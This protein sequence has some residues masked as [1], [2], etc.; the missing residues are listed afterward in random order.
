[1]REFRG[2]ETTREVWAVIRAAHPEIEAIGSYSAPDGGETHPEHGRMYTAY[3][4][5]DSPVP[6]ISAET[7]WEIDRSDPLNR[8]NQQDRCWLCVPIEE[9]T[10]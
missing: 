4:F 8:I 2:V 10:E 1:M 6:L 5:E 3:G 7:V 9:V